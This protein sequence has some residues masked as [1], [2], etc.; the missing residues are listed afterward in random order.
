MGKKS[1]WFGL[2]MNLFC[3][4][5]WVLMFIAGTDVW[6]DTGSHDFWTLHG[7]PYDDLKVFAWAFYLLLPA[8]VVM[9]AV[10]GVAL[11]R[12]KASL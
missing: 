9:L 10:Q 3:L 1:V 11:R 2:L 12:R 4:I 6:H 8:L 5:C 7:P